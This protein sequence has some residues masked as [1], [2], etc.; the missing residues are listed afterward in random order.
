MKRLTEILDQ[1]VTFSLPDWF[2]PE[3]LE[4]TRTKKY[5]PG[6]AYAG[7]VES[8]DYENSAVDALFRLKGLKEVSTHPMGKWAVFQAKPSQ[9]AKLQAKLERFLRRYKEAK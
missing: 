5:S 8:T 4:Y 9:V 7:Q 6:H 2:P 3:R 1:T